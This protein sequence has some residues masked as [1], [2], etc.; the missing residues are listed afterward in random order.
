M[1]SG[2]VPEAATPGGESAADGSTYDR[3]D[4][5]KPA[6]L[7]Q[8][9]LREVDPIVLRRWVERFHEDFVTDEQPLVDL[10]ALPFE[11]VLNT[12]P[13]DTVSEAFTRTKR[14][15]VTAYYDRTGPKPEMLPDPSRERPIVYQLYGSLQKP[16]SMILSDS[17]RLDFIVKVA[18]GVP[19]LPI[20]L[21]SVLRDND[22][23]FLFLGFD[24][25]DWHFRVLLHILSDDAT[26]NYTSFAGELE[27]APL[28]AETQDFYRMNHRIHFFGGELA[29]FCAQ[30]RQRWE[31][32]R[33]DEL[34][35][36]SS[37]PPPAPSSD[38]PT[39]FICHAS[40]DAAHAQRIADG[41]RSAG[42]ATWLDKENLRGGDRWD[43]M[44]EQTLKREVSYVVVLQSQ[45]M[46]LKDVGY[47]NREISIAIDRSRDY[48]VPRVFLIPAVIDHPDN[49]LELLDLQR[50][51]SVDVTPA[52]GVT[53]LVRAIMR[54]LS[55][56]GR[57]G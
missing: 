54:D 8:A 27:S 12:S 5:W 28:D 33:P 30:L 32:D 14:E 7:A 47:V 53:D 23:S 1:S 42:I 48:R 44:I 45:A 24:L 57:I 55:L 49:K 46:K 25:A 10:A 43:D 37:S 13:I 35:E 16:R 4:P 21:T 38:A 39:V 52:A 29:E 36:V 17:D 26:R 11:L 41:L 56:Q 22:R 3:L 19:A 6:A 20:N 15:T 31:A 40:E 51:Q 34:D 18:R 50:L 2:V 9:I